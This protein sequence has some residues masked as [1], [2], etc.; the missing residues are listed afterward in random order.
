MSQSATFIAPQQAHSDVLGSA[1]LRVLVTGA[2]GYTGGRI[3]QALAHRGGTEVLLG[4]RQALQSAPAWLV[5]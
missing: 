1:A 5:R 3:A 4:T 2:Y